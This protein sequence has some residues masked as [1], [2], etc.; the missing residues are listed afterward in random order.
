M[1]LCSRFNR[2]ALSS[3]LVLLSFFALSATIFAQTPDLHLSLSDSLNA[4]PCETGKIIEV[5]MANYNDT[6]VAFE[7]LLVMDRPNVIFFQ[8]SFDTSGTLISGWEYVNVEHLGTEYNIRITARA[9]DNM[10]YTTPG[11]VPQSG[12]VPLIKIPIDV[13]SIPD[14]LTDRTVLI[15]FGGPAPCFKNNQGNCIGA[16]P[17]EDY[18]ST[19][20]RCIDWADPPENTICNEYIQI[21]TPPYDSLAIDTTIYYVVDTNLVHTED[22]WID[23]YPGMVGDYNG[24]G[25]YNLADILANI[26]AVYPPGGTPPFDLPPMI[27]RDFSCDCDNNLNDILQLINYIYVVPIGQPSTCSCI[28][29][30]NGCEL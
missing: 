20:Y 1:S 30:R 22:H 27:Y 5:N 28:E 11:I 24:D 26:V 7:F 6:V 17:V 13:M 19:F 4:C 21:P 8:E 12:S 10:P 23:I 3:V 29:W 25:L 15:L 2:R 9:E 18:D 16:V 14:T